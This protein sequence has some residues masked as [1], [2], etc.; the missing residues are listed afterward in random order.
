MSNKATL[1]QKKKSLTPKLRFK[2]FTSSWETKKLGD[3][4]DISKL[5]GYEYTKHIVYSDT[6]K[7]IA[8]RALNIKR[9]GLDLR[10][11]KY[12]DSSDL[13]KLNRSKLYIGDLMFTYIGANIG[14]VALINENERFYLAPNVARIRADK[15][16]MDYYFIHQYFNI[17]SF[18]N[19]EISRFIASSSQPALSMES[20]RKFEVSIPTLPEQQKIASFLSAVDEKIQQLTRKKELLEQYKK[21]VMQ[22][23]FSG[24]LRFK[25]ENAKPYPKWHWKNGNELFDSIS[26][27]NHNSD[28][29]I[30]AI[31]QD[32]GAVP[33]DMI[34]YQMSV[35]DNSIASY[36]VVQK[37]DFIISLRSFQGG[38]E[39]SNYKGICSPAY[40]ILRPCS[41]DVYSD[42][43]RYYL[44]TSKYIMQLQRNLEGIRDGKMISYKYFS[45]IKL[46]FPSKDEQQ[47]IAGFLTALDTKIEKVG[48]Q[49]D[50]TQD[51]KKGLLQQMFV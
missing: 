20:I 41:E 26:D 35:T 21:G 7:I 28:L 45:E 51:F 15:A 2:E 29:P 13:T 18:L 1:A 27:K 22:Q 17:P 3:L 34:N 6:G 37:G 31:T 39:Y 48:A 19:Q 36:K 33:R 44:K 47:K 50:K 9:N 23:F 12:I 49:I 46:P 30:L 40:N 25:D 10:D 14:D 42:F 8:L 5:A 11:V 4:S 24:K 32:Q 38:I 43:Y 16:R